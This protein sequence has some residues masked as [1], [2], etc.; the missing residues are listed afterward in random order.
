MYAGALVLLAFTPLALGSCAALPFVV[1]LLLVIIARLLAEEAYLRAH[2][3]G[4]EA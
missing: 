1:P 4:Y 2:L 3:D